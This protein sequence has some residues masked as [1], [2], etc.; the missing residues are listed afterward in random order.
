[1]KRI[2]K[3]LRWAAA[4]ITVIW[5]ILFFDLRG[6]SFL[7]GGHKLEG[8]S[9]HAAEMEST[10][11]FL[12]S[13]QPPR[14]YQH[15]ESMFK[16]ESY[17]ENKFAMLGYKVRKQDVPTKYGTFHNIIA[18][19]GSDDTKDVVVVGAHYDVCGDYPGADDNATG[20]QVFLNLQGFL[21]SISQ[22]LKFQLSWSSIPPR[23]RHFSQAS[24]WEVLFMR[25][26][27]RTLVSG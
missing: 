15:L 10:V 23:S 26:V 17:I 27:L 14:N 7:S 4:G 19:F 20:L 3:L 5:A 9:V 8:V 12:G 18:R 11:R 1:M 2:W 6:P 16:V 22:A 25:R 24:K 13:M 21:K